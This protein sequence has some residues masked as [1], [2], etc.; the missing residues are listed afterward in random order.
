MTSLLDAVKY[1]VGDARLGLIV[2]DTFARVML[3]GDENSV[4]D[5]G[6]VIAA[7]QRMQEATG[8]AV[9]FLHHGNKARG[10]LRGSTAFLGALDTSVKAERTSDG[11]G[12]IVTLSCEKQK[13]AAPFDD[14]TLMSRAM[15]LG[16]EKESLVLELAGPAAVLARNRLQVLAVLVELAGEDGLAAK[17]WQEA[18]MARHDKIGKS[19]FNNLKKKLDEDDMI[20]SIARGIWKPTAKGVSLAL[21]LRS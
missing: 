9:L 5:V 11:K 4:K 6:T 14:V 1:T 13:D 3:G 19:T 16:G 17:A 15:T 7:A 18:V 12:Q 21:G 8:A 2:F 10:D 20:E